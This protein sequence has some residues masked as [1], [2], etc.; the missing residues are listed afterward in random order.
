MLN[1]TTLAFLRQL[2]RGIAE[3]FGPNCEV[4]VRPFGQQRQPHRRRDRKQSTSPT[5]SS[6]TALHIVL[7]ALHGDRSALH[8]QIGYLTK[9]KDGRI[10]KS[11]T[12]YIRDE[13]GDAVGIFSINFD[14]TGLLMVESALK[15]IVST[16]APEK[17]PERIS[18]NVNELLDE[19]IS[20]S[21]RLV[22]KPVALMTKDDKVKAIQFLNDTGAFLITKSGDKVS[23]YFGISKYTLYSYIDAKA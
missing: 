5:A 13:N 7:E 23:K 22:G 2:A 14:I 12:I 9:T 15:P 1:A 10:L 4:V 17:E 21:V 19:L 11:S 8:D 16:A 3:Q 18:Q 6:A 20:Q